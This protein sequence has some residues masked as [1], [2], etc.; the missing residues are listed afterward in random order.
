V[1]TLYLSITGGL[2][3][4]DAADP[5]LELSPWFALIFCVYMAIAVFCVLNT[6]TGILVEKANTIVQ[7]DKESFLL[8]EMRKRKKWVEEVKDSFI[9]ADTNGSGKLNWEEFNQQMN[10]VNVQM[11]LKALG[12][13]VLITEPEVLFELFDFDGDGTI[14]IQEFATGVQKLHGKANAVDMAALKVSTKIIR[15]DVDQIKDCVAQLV[16]Q[17]PIRHFAR[18]SP[19]RCPSPGIS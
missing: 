3:W 4:S 1:Y 15:K 6:V 18:P 9:R 10:D 7:I 16:R 5:L 19:P 13:D 12:I 14:E 11:D 2:N 8:H 17:A